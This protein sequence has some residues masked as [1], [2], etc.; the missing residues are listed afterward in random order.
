MSHIHKTCSEINIVKKDCLSISRI[1]LPLVTYFRLASLFYLHIFLF[2]NWTLMNL[3][4]KIQLDGA[5]RIS[6]WFLNTLFLVS[7]SAK[8]D[9]TE[10]CIMPYVGISE[11]SI[12]FMQ[13][14]SR[15]DLFQTSF[16]CL[17]ILVLKMRIYFRKCQLRKY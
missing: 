16:Y 1:S 17:K 7:W 15:Q 10:T 2:F 9:A 8:N 6:Y 13:I 3:L 11:I 14:I 4:Q 12:S 5:F